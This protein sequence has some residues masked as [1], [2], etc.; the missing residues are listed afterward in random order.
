M[1]TAAAAPRTCQC[2]RVTQPGRVLCVLTLVLAATAVAP[3][4]PGDT[5]AAALPEPRSR[6]IDPKDGQSA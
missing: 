5:T 3:T 1:S 4:V 6:F 2:R